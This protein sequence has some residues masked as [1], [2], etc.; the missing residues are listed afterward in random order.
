ML[1]ASLRT[2]TCHSHVDCL[3]ARQC[4]FCHRGRLR[5]WRSFVPRFLRQLRVYLCPSA[6]AGIYNKKLHLGLCRSSRELFMTIGM[7]LDKSLLRRHRS[8]LCVIFTSSFL[9][10]LQWFQH[11]LLGVNITLSGGVAQGNVFQ[12]CTGETAY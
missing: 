11:S 5:C 1:V 6:V 9:V 2:W 8:F 7:V 12:C 10:L 4:P 3:K